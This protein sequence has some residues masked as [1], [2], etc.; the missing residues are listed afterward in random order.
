LPGPGALLRRIDAPGVWQSTGIQIARGTHVN[1]VAW[2]AWQIAR[3][4]SSWTDAD[5]YDPRDEASMLKAAKL[6]ALRPERFPRMGLEARIG[7]HGFRS[8]RWRTLQAADSGELLFRPW[9]PLA[10]ANDQREFNGPPLP[11]LLGFAPNFAEAPWVG[12]RGF[13][14]VAVEVLP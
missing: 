12:V 8:G 2:G 4:E 14:T 6:D 3:R 13:V 9:L 10:G 1:L 5:G 7:R 11:W